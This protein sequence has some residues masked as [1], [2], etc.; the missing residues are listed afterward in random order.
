MTLHQNIHLSTRKGYIY[1]SNSLHAIR[2]DVCSS[3]ASEGLQGFWFRYHGFCFVLW[4]FIIFSWSVW[5]LIILSWVFMVLVGFNCFFIGLWFVFHGVS[6]CFMV[7]LISFCR[8]PDVSEI[9]KNYIF[10]APLVVLWLCQIVGLIEGYVKFPSL[11]IITPQVVQ[12]N[13]N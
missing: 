10:L 11:R 13:F 12:W 8:F 4:V 2:C 1:T 3:F 7:F 5:F 6:W 9:R